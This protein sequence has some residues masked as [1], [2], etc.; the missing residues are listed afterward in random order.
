MM[1]IGLN[2]YLV[3]SAL[4]FSIGLL[5]LV[6]RKNL[7]I[8]FMCIELLL[9]SVNLV[10]IS[11]ARYSATMDGHVVAMFVMALAAAEAAVGLAIVVS[12]F[13]NRET[14]DATDWYIMGG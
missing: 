8:M 13:K 3:L 9:N 12:M 2:H 14:V 1:T 10:F 6:T 4:L 5:G 11:I 7:L